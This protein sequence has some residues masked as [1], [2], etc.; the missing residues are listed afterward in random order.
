MTKC[1]RVF[2]TILCFMVYLIGSALTGVVLL[3]ALLMLGNLYVRVMLWA[4]TRF[5]QLLG[6]Q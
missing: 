6:V 4:L 5:V 3:A 2:K 1:F